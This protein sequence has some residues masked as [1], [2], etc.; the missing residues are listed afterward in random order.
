MKLMP[1]QIQRKWKVS[2]C[3]SPHQDCGNSVG[4][5]Q[6]QPEANRLLNFIKSIVNSASAIAHHTKIPLPKH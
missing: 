3:R 6:L 5:A 2:E 4:L 1:V